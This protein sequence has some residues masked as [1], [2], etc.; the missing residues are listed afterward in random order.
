[1]RAETRFADLGFGPPGLQ[2]VCAGAVLESSTFS[3]VNAA[4][5]V[6]VVAADIAAD[7]F[8]GCLVGEDIQFENFDAD[9][10][11]KAASE[12]VCCCIL[13]LVHWYCTDMR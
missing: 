13:S 6:G 4:K 3:N 9:Y 1:M 2:I 12:K 10:Y 5:N 7:C 11:F 8:T